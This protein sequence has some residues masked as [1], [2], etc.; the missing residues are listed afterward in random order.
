MKNN[1]V[2]CLFHLNPQYFHNVL[3]LLLGLS[4]Q[5]KLQK[6]QPNPSN[7]TQRLQNC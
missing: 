6:C 2:N 3:R 1:I 4:E 7:D 5:F